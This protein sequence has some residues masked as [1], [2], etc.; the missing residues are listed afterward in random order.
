MSSS[1]ELRD[2][3]ELGTIAENLLFCQLPTTKFAKE[4]GGC[5]SVC[6]TVEPSLGRMYTC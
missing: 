2:V 4:G 1:A 3:H 5:K 6:T